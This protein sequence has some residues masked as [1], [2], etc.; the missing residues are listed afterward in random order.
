MVV[1]LAMR[2]RLWAFAFLTLTAGFFVWR[3]ALAA[4]EFSLHAS[5]RGLAVLD[6][7]GNEVA[8]VPGLIA[9]PAVAG[10]G[11]GTWLLAGLESASRPRLAL[12]TGGNGQLRA[13]P[14]KLPN[15]SS[16]RESLQLAP[17]WLAGQRIP[18]LVW[19]E[20]DDPQGLEIRA[21]A[22]NGKRWTRHHTIAPR[23]PGSQL[24]LTGVEF[25]GQPLVV[26]TAFDGQDDEVLW[27]LLTDK[28]WSHPRRLDS[29]N[30]VPDVAPVLAVASG[31]VLAAWNRL[32]GDAY[33]VAYARF[34]GRSWS[35]V[36][37]AGPAGSSTPAFVEG[38]HT[39]GLLYRTGSPAGFELLELDTA[40]RPTGRTASW[41]PET[42]GTRR[43]EPPRSVELGPSGARFAFAVPALEVDVPWRSEPLRR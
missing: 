1:S 25:A 7:R 3:P 16:S 30:R 23:A 17:T 12:W 37:F 26:W 33:R 31:G 19:L 13:Q 22:W 32:E 36:T 4:A 34:D 24:A 39:L 41:Q 20:G 11:G 14:R 29:D 5:A 8:S 18:H 42:P 6:A 27:S 9:E 21:A 35:A 43:F 10:A 15:P 38:A 40:G 28:H 2:Q